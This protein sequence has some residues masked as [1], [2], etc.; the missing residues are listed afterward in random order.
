LG[1][2]NVTAPD[3]VSSLRSNSVARIPSLLAPVYCFNWFAS[4]GLGSTKTLEYASRVIAAYRPYQENDEDATHL[5][6]ANAGVDTGAS[7]TTV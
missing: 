7:R 1:I 5:R 6:F 4:S 2:F 3:L